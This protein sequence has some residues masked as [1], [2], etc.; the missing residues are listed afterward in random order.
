VRSCA[1]LVP[2][3]SWVQG[4]N[5]LRG[6][7][8]SAKLLPDP[9]D[10]RRMAL[11]ASTRPVRG[12]APEP[13]RSQPPRAP[14]ARPKVR[15]RF[16]RVDPGR[17]SPNAVAERTGTVSFGSSPFG[18]APDPGR[19]CRAHSAR[20]GLAFT[21]SRLSLVTLTGGRVR[22]DR[23]Y[24]RT[25]SARPV[26]PSRGADPG[27]GVGAR[28]ELHGNPGQRVVARSPPR[29]GLRAQRDIFRALGAEQGEMSVVRTVEAG[30]RQR[31]SRDA[32]TS[33]PD[34]ERLPA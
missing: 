22:R 11:I 12:P 14:V 31:K 27:S 19:L 25:R 1:Q 8:A 16:G 2:A 18:A 13:K 24:R 28:A 5:T 6:A 15:G 21:A 20:S 3:A 23:G 26:A 10:L 33:R 4:P 29:F 30:D 34:V 7:S 9:E 17:T 32:L